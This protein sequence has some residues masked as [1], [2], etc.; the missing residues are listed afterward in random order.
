MPFLHVMSHRQ[1]QTSQL[2]SSIV[3]TFSHLLFHTG[4][5]YS[6]LPPSLCTCQSMSLVGC[7][8]ACF[9]WPGC[10]CLPILPREALCH[11]A[12]RAAGVHESRQS[13]PARYVSDSRIGTYACGHG[14]TATAR[15]R[16]PIY[17]T[18]FS[19]KQHNHVHCHSL[20]VQVYP[21]PTLASRFLAAYWCDVK[22]HTANGVSV[23]IKTRHNLVWVGSPSFKTRKPFPLAMKTPPAIHSPQGI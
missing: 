12:P 9:T 6:R 17:C 2:Q 13:Y 18:R 4:A 15:T 16:Y 1:I 10:D 22:L 21:I 5:S 19:L 8:G 7:T 14:I 23:S 20:I 11:H 3:C